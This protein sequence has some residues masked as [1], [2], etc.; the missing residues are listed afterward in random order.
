MLNGNVGGI[1]AGVFFVLPAFFL[2]LGLTWTYAVHG[3]VAWVAAVFYGLQAAVIALVT[4]AAIRLGSKALR[5]PILVGIGVVA[6]L[7]IFF[8]H[9]PFP[10]IVAAAIVVGLVG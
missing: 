6:F 4:V 8:A 5:N 1:A 2:I 3:D 10:I 7:A 9:V